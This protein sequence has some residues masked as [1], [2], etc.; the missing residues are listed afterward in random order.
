[1]YIY[2][3]TCNDLMLVSTFKIQTQL[4]INTSSCPINKLS[5][6]F[7]SIKY[8]TYVYPYISLFVCMA[9][10]GRNLTTSLANNVDHIIVSWWPFVNMSRLLLS[11]LVGGTHRSVFRPHR[12]LTDIT[13]SLVALVINSMDLIVSLSLAC[14]DT[15]QL[16]SSSS[17]MANPA[18][19][20]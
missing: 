2:K 15:R 14:H 6:I 10:I 7:V 9:I 13:C 20:R 12:Q 3:E 17:T 5:Y 19:R 4:E 16:C 18:C 1:M 11:S 8:T